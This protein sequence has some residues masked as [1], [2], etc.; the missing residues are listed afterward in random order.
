MY[1]WKLT[2]I[3]VSSVIY[4][5]NEKLINTQ[6]HS[7]LYSLTVNQI[8]KYSNC[9]LKFPMPYRKQSTHVKPEADKYLK[10]T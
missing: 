5:I 10:F 1:I 4:A 6:W 7:F 9:C 2:C 3:S 8:E